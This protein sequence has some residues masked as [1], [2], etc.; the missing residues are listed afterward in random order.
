[1]TL[2]YPGA[3]LTITQLL[4]ALQRKLESGI[5]SARLSGGRALVESTVSISSGRVHPCCSVNLHDFLD[6]ATLPQVD[7][8]EADL[9]KGLLATRSLRNS[10]QPANR[11]PPELIVH[12]SSYFRGLKEKV[13]LTATHV[14]TY[15]RQ[16]I[17]SCPTLWVNISNEHRRLI[18]LYLDRSKSSPL[19]LAVE[20]GAAEQYE[21]PF[22]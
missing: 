9:R 5:H 11:L 22:A 19:R 8:L 21:F 2:P 1:M 12:I 6:A 20:G 18:P 16:T 13:L 3:D 10:Y 15:W 14:C 4:H 17:I 7:E